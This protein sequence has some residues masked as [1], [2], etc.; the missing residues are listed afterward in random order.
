MM[1][2]LDERELLAVPNT[3]IVWKLKFT[4]EWIP[5]WGKTKKYGIGR[6]RCGGGREELNAFIDYQIL[7]EQTERER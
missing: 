7:V 3:R 1:L 2:F 6:D 4:G 5:K